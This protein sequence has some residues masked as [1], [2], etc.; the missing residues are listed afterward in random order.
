M[1]TRGIPGGMNENVEDALGGYQPTSARFAHIDDAA[2]AR[3]MAIIARYRKSGWSPGEPCSSFA[4][5]AWLAATGEDLHE[6]YE[7]QSNPTSLDEGIKAANH[8]K[9][10]WIKQH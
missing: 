5:D 6:S 8:G 7:G 9:P 10:F 4:H 1:N 3:L 2:E